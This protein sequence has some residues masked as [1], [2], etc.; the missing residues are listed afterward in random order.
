MSQ[1]TK[2]EQM[3]QNYYITFQKIFLMTFS[4]TWTKFAI[5]MLNLREVSAIFKTLEEVS[6]TIR[7]L[8]GG[9][10][11]YPKEY[12]KSMNTQDSKKDLREF[13]FLHEIGAQMQRRLDGDDGLNPDV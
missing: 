11:N 3:K 1:E 5:K 6:A 13:P 8:K 4:F 9:F 2:R 7:N 10:C 12:G